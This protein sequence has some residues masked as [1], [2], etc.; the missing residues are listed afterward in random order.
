MKRSEIFYQITSL[1]ASLPEYDIE[2]EKDMI[3]APKCLNE[4]MHDFLE[5]A[6]CAEKLEDIAE[7]KAKYSQFMDKFRER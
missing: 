5:M 4:L 1:L 3:P 6:I 2:F 7:A